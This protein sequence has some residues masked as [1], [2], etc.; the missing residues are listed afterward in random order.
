MK[1]RIIFLVSIALLWAHTALA[2]ALKVGVINLRP[3]GYI[4]ADG[5]PAGQ[6]IEVFDTL[7]ERSGI[8][9]TYS[10]MPIPRVKK[11]L[12]SGLTDMTVIFRRQEMAPH[13]DFLGLVL[14]YNYYLVGRKG[15]HFNKSSIKSITRVGYSRDEEDV[16]KKCFSDQYNSTAKLVPAS[17]YGNLIKMLNGKRFDAATIPSKGLKSYLDKVGADEKEIGNLFVLCENEA[18]L[19]VSKKSP[20]LNKTIIKTLSDTLKKMR[21]DGTIERIAEKYQEV[22]K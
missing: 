5:K 3:W 11:Y 7:S 13:V 22:A 12:I 18:Y 19:Q 15:E 10:V 2:D 20:N 16:V 8:P 6:H 21:E 17:N 4:G 14:P 9:F 1:Q